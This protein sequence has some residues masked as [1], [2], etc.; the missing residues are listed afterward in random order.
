VV[1]SPRALDQLTLL[2]EWWRIN[3]PA[4]SVDV[5]SEVEHAFDILTDLPNIGQRYIH[6]ERYRLYRLGKTPYMLFYQVDEEKGELM[7]EAVWS[8]SREP[9]PDLG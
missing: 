9:G 7:I 5:E 4:A 3:R 8:V 6:D 1:I 2:A